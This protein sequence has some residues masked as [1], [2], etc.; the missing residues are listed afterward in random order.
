MTWSSVSRA[1]FWVL[2]CCSFLLCTLLYAGVAVM[3][4][5]MFGEA[6][7]SQI[8]LNLPGQFLAS[9]IAVWTTVC[10][11]LFQNIVFSSLLT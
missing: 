10:H 8:T 2:G 5:T 4:F 7:A 9:K 3:G 1:V 11:Q 6:T